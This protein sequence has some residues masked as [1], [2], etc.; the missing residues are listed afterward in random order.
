MPL[1]TASGP[2]GHPD[3]PDRETVNSRGFRDG[4][5]LWDYARVAERYGFPDSAGTHENAVIWS[6]RVA[7]RRWVRI[8]FVAG[9]VMRVEE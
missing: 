7:E 2:L 3:F 6:Y 5:L 8:H 1:L 9:V 4:L